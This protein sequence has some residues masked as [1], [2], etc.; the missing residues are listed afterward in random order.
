[1]SRNVLVL[2]SAYNGGNKI[3][4]QVESIILQEEVNVSLFIRDDGSDIDTINILRRLEKKYP[5]KIFCIYGANLGFKQ[6]F[7]EL[8]YMAF[9]NFDYYAFSDQDDIWFSDKLISC[10][11]LMESDIKENKINKEGNVKRLQSNRCKLAHCNC[12]SVDKKLRLRS[13]QEKRIPYPPNHKMAISTEFFQGCGMVW[14]KKLMELIQTYRPKNNNISHDYWVGLLGYWIGQVY[15]CKDPKFYH[16]RYENNESMD[17]DVK[18]GRLKRLKNFITGDVIYMNPVQDLLEGYT[19]YMSEE[20]KVFLKTLSNYQ[21]SI[22]E[23]FRI[24]TDWEFRKPSMMATMLLKLA[25]AMNR[26]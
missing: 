3:I 7:M 17:G 22:K 4:R 24:L 2:L 14:D 26:F 21:H 1:M 6:S 12:I 13:E 9:P 16:I 20:D 8:I 19:N 23:K 15:F 18:K 5:E 10:I 25:V 11:K